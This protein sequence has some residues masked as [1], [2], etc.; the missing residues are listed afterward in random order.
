MAVVVASSAAMGFAWDERPYEDAALELS[1]L[2]AFLQS[3]QERLQETV[4]R[5]RQKM[6]EFQ[7][8]AAASIPCGG[9]D[10]A[11]SVER[12]IGDATGGGEIG[13][14]GV[15]SCFSPADS[16]R[17]SVQ[18]VPREHS[19]GAI[20]TEAHSA[21]DAAA[22]RAA[23]EV[24]SAVATAAIVEADDTYSGAVAADSGS[25]ADLSAASHQRFGGGEE[26]LSM[27]DKQMDRG[28]QLERRGN[29]TQLGAP[30][31]ASMCIGPAPAVEAPMPPKE[32]TFQPPI[33]FPPPGTGEWPWLPPDALACQA[34][35]KVQ[36]I[37]APPVVK[38][39]PVVQGIGAPP[40]GGIGSN[41]IGGPPPK[42]PPG[43][44]GDFVPPSKPPPAGFF[45]PGRGE[46][47]APLRQPPPMKKAPPVISFDNMV[48]PPMVSS[49]MSAGPSCASQPPPPPKVLF[50]M[51]DGARLPPASPLRYAKPPP[52]AKLPD[53]GPPPPLKAPPPDVVRDAPPV[54][55][56]PPGV[57]AFGPPK[58]PPPPQWPPSCGFSSTP[59]TK[60]PPPG[61]EGAPPPAKPAPLGAI[62][63]FAEGPSMGGQ[64]LV[65]AIP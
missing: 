25:G 9:V 37:G 61:P 36:G 12:R 42:G 44:G 39:P 30:M 26:W 23:A 32:E 50:S 7:A 48:Q 63:A 8:A 55:A 20:S 28:V 19:D 17:Q 49:H 57:E 64:P 29:Q 24:A 62:A 27:P 52:V 43:S 34:P 65:K 51:E 11:V 22:I 31:S 21:P 59:P 16:S 56:L 45:P 14:A 53:P 54:K 33:N 1:K 47:S 10:Q 3:V 46:A 35:T 41:N 38:A 40:V 58:G 15:V 13:I 5:D 18:S 4:A 6:R 2:V 60:P